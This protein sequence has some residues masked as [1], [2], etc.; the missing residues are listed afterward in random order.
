MYLF[1]L[2]ELIFE[3]SLKHVVSSVQE[4]VVCIGSNILICLPM[5]R[6][7]SMG[8]ALSISIG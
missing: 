1:S 8:F 5:A 7:N 4:V 6:H 3:V 2:S